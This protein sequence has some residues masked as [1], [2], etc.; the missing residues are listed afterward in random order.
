[1]TH[2]ASQGLSQQAHELNDRQ[3]EAIAGGVESPAQV[4]DNGM[5]ELDEGMKKLDQ[6]FRNW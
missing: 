1:M 4:I 5:N 3:L 6:A 2:Q